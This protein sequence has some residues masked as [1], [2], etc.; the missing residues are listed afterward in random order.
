[1]DIQSFPYTLDVRDLGKKVTNRV[2]VGLGV[3]GLAALVMGVLITFWP[4]DSAA[5]LAVLLG[6]YWIIA[7]VS[8]C[9]VGIFTKGISGWSRVLDFV[10]AVLFV[11]GGIIMI[12]NPIISAATLAIVVGVML[13][14]LWIF[15]GI[16]AIVQSGDVPSHGWAIFFGIVSILAG[17][18][19]LFIPIWSAAALF[20]IAGIGLIVLGIVQIVRAFRFGHGSDVEEVVI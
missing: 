20:W 8:Y 10:M 5:V 19:V 9:C 4:G 7:G 18:S 12:A 3:I 1:M 17:I 13:G 2:R 11:L 16:L 6:I 15:E 14:V